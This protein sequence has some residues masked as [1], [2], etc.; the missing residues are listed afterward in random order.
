MKKRRH[1]HDSVP[2]SAA[3]GSD[4]A[5]RAEMVHYEWHEA[6]Q[7]H[8]RMAKRHDSSARADGGPSRVGDVAIAR[9]IHD[10]LAYVSALT[11]SGR[12]QTVDVDYAGATL[13]LSF[14]HGLGHVNGV[15]VPIAEVVNERGLM[16]DLVA[17][18]HKEPADVHVTVVIRHNDDHTTHL[19]RLLQGTR[20]P[21]HVGGVQQT[22]TLD[23]MVLLWRLSFAE[24]STATVVAM[25][26]GIPPL[27]TDISMGCDWGRRQ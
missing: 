23:A 25:A 5:I 6:H 10:I 24:L 1:H 21:A 26:R 13:G 11:M 8:C 4:A 18:W 19:Q 16:E 17:A 2:A 12:V 20:E 27:P 3:S 14:P 15:V 7:E 9:N 22:T